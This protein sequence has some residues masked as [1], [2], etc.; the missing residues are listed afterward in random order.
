MSI[1]RSESLRY[2]NQHDHAHTNAMQQNMYVHS[3]HT[4]HP[5]GVPVVTCLSHQLTNGRIL[6]APTR[7]R[8]SIHTKCSHSARSLQSHMF[9]PDTQTEDAQLRAHRCDGTRYGRSLNWTT[10]RDCRCRKP[11]RMRSVPVSQLY[12]PRHT[13]HTRLWPVYPQE[14]RQQQRNHKKHITYWVD[15]GVCGAAVYLWAY[16]IVYYRLDTG[17]MLTIRRLRR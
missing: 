10:T 13:I 15:Q 16:L 4:S 7:W 8:R 11:N 9:S 12:S 2:T 3:I 5:M 6:S 14:N 17:T 1:D